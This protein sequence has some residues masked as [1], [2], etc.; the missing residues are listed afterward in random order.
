[1]PVSPRR[2][3][4]IR[5]DLWWGRSNHTVRLE[6]GVPSVPFAWVEAAG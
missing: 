1:V 6:Q 4:P 3:R 2:F 5:P